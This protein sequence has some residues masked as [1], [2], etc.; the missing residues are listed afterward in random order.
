MISFIKKIWLEKPL[1]L[2]IFLGVF[3]RLLA[4]LF[5]KGYGMHDDHFLIIEASQSWV[6]GYD[7][8]NWL[9]GSGAQ[10]PSGHSLFYTGIHFIFFKILNFISI[11]DPQTKMYLVRLLHALF[12]ILTIILGH[13]ITLHY[14]GKK[15][16]LKVAA[17]LSLL[18]IMPILSVRNLIEVVCVPFLMYATWLLIKADEKNA[19][20]YYL[21]SGFIAGLAFSIRFQCILF[22]GGFGIYILTQKKWKQAFFFGL[23]CITSM[24]LT[25]GPID[26]YNWGYP[27]AEFIEYLKYNMDNAFS[28]STQ[29]WYMYLILLSG[30]LIPPISL[31]LLFGFFRKWKKHLLL[32]LPS[33]IFLVYHSYFPNKQERFILPIIPFIIILGTIGWSE[34]ENNSLF[35]QKRQKLMRN[36]W[37]FFWSINAIPLVFLSVSYSKQDRVEAMTYL[38]KKSDVKSI[39]VEDSNHDSYLMLPRFYLNKWVRIYGITSI[40]EYNA[41][42]KPSSNSKDEAP[43][44]VIFIQ[45]G[46]LEKR[47]NDFKTNYA[48]I[49]LETKIEQGLLD[50]TMHWLNPVN[51]SQNCYIYKIKL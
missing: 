50:K 14:A 38:S 8:N 17:L 41:L 51:K 23:A 40:L 49:T 27:F 33:F 29:P 24:T 28:Y 44:Y 6:D 43:N 1:S 42:P 30:I 9:P 3:F 48:D 11:K 25:Q 21:L 31:F 20:K 22:I 45:D 18:F 37:I 35:W 26:Y 15:E 7:Y 39:I 32:F 5:S 19:I 13:K 2:I 16:A 34:Y 36:F 12:S 46:N 10:Q 4:V 47:L